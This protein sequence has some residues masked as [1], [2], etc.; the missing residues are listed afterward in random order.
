[1]TIIG[2]TTDATSEAGAVFPSEVPKVTLL[3]WF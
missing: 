1:L 3:G 2:N